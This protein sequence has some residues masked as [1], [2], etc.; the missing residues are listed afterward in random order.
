MN[1]I[2]SVGSQT[3]CFCS[4]ERF[5]GNVITKSI[6]K[7]ILTGAWGRS[8]RGLL[9]L[10]SLFFFLLVSCLS[11]HLAIWLRPLTC[12]YI[13]VMFKKVDSQFN[14]QWIKTQ[15]CRF[16]SDRNIGLCQYTKLAE[17][18]KVE[19]ILAYSRVNVAAN[20][21]SVT[22]RE[23]DIHVCFS[24]SFEYFTFGW[25]SLR[26]ILDTRYNSWVWLSGAILPRF[27]LRRI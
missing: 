9:T 17:T 5:P 24:A 3:F 14:Q 7:E 20:Q 6:W 1:R 8:G 16:V 22:Q 4:R 27:T 26:F 23:R 12:N 10:I 11:F 13:T 15:N 19:I 25:I 2:Y 21:L 18:R